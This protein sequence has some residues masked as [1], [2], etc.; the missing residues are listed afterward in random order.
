MTKAN[1]HQLLAKAQ[2]IRESLIRD[3]RA[4]HRHPELAYQEGQTAALVAQRLKELDL[5]EVHESV[6]G[7]GVVGLLRG[8]RPGKTVLLRADMDA[9]PIE[10][11]SGA[12]YASECAGV[13]HAC[14]HD[15]HTAMLLGAAR[16]LA[17]RRDFAGNVKFMF[18]PAEEGGAGALRM[19]EAG[20]LES[21]Q[22]D[23]AFALHVDAL[24]YAGQVATRSGP[25]MAAADRFTIVVQGAGGHAARPHLAVDPVVIASHIVVALQT[26]VSREVDPTELAVVTIGSLAAGTTFNVIPDTA[27]LQGTVRTY[28]PEVQELLERRLGEVASGV[29]AAMRASVSV[30][31][32]RGYP[33]LVNHVSGSDL[34]GQ[35]VREL[36]GPDAWAE[37]EQ[38]MG[39][40]DFSYVLQHRPG[41]MFWLGVR[42]PTWPEPRPIHSPT[43]DIDETAL[44]IGTAVM[45][46]TALRY[47]AGAPL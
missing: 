44:P 42:N 34:V 6:G 25:S 18:Q 14:G 22:V 1:T 17:E 35:V 28:L 33:P 8:S 23:A 10:E 29:A 21:P 38:V 47:L 9:L 36:L 26:L 12:P 37:K 32:Q 13:M 24:K 39:A 31:Y 11:P 4:I 5:D 30:D 16:L 2:E 41:A 43:F 15:G 45:A 40:E 20:V 27:T 46:E 19:I 7:T 3:R